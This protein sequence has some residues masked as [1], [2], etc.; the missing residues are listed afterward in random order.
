MWDGPVLAQQE[1]EPPLSE[2]ELQRR[3]LQLLIGSLDRMQREREREQQET[4]RR[5]A[6]RLLES[7]EDARGRALHEPHIVF[8]DTGAPPERTIADLIEGDGGAFYIGGTSDPSWRWCGGQIDSAETKETKS[9]RG[10]IMPGHRLKWNYLHVVAVKEGAEGGEVEKALIVK[11]KALHQEM[12]Q[13]KALDSRGLSNDGTNFMYL[14]TG[15][16]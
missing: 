14:A 3:R 4:E 1:E 6:L 9:E 10:E 16:L 2:E 7:W 15:L 5:R 8:H 12:C 13:N 11:F